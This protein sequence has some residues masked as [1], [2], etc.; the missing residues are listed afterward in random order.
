ML[1]DHTLVTRAVAGVA[2]RQDLATIT[3]KTLQLRGALVIHSDRIVTA[4]LALFGFSRFE[5]P[6]W[7]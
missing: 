3:D 1:G 7:P 6:R 4:E 5:R 2:A